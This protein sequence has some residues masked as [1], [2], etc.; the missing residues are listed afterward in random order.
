MIAVNCILDTAD[1][2]PARQLAHEIRERDGGLPGV[3]ALAFLLPSRQR[4]Q[5]SM[6]LVDLERTGLQDACEA[7][8]TGAGR[9]G[10][11][12]ES[13]EVVGL[14]PASELA[15]CDAAFLDWAAL[16]PEQTIE[17]RVRRQLARRSANAEQ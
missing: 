7:V 11:R 8:R 12:V 4:V 13:V 6:N 2:P 3:R 10:A 14:V 15:R 1:L 17:D 9:V 5:V 16:G